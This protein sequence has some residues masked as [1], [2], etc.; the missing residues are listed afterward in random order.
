MTASQTTRSSFFFFYLI[1]FRPYWTPVTTPLTITPHMGS[2]SLSYYPHFPTANRKTR[3][4]SRFF[5]VKFSSKCQDPCLEALP[6]TAR[7][8]AMLHFST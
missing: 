2:H 5:T 4:S 6:T 3:S 8:I 1:N 7:P